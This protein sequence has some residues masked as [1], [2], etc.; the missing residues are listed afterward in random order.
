MKSI[1]LLI[2]FLLT[3]NVFGKELPAKF[4]NQLIYL[5]PTLDSGE[6]ITFFTDTGGGFNA[7]AQ[8]F[9]TKYKWP[10]ITEKGGD[11]TLLL[12]PM[13]NYKLNKGIPL[14]GLNNFMKGN[15]FLV[16]REE[17][18][19]KDGFLGG[20]WHAEKV[21]GF[22]YLN[23]TMAVYTEIQSLNIKS[24]T[25]IE[26]GFQKDSS[27]NYTT[28]FPSIEITVDNEIIPMLFDTGA[29]AHLSNNAQKT[30]NTNAKKIGTSFISASTF[31][32]WRQSNPQWPVIESGD[33]FAGDSMIQVP[34]VS[35][36]GK[37]I[38]PVWFTRRQDHNF[39]SYMSSMMDRKIDGAIG[40]SLLKYLHVIVDYPNEVAYIKT[41]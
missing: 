34:K 4:D 38:G 24:F 10:T 6:K 18:D 15:L 31:E 26:L 40:G 13:P 16:N 28:A 7:I 36:A 33:L 39:H 2:T 37:T 1:I 12:T 20:R 35:I 29:T 41:N 30:L 25:K 3:F 32:R 17:I 21:I 11:E 5:T 19:G 27:G 8:D 23:R 14:G 9:H 22:N